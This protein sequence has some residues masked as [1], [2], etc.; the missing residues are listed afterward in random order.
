ME[1]QEILLHAVENGAADIL[2]VAGMPVAYKVNGAIVREGDRLLPP[3]TRRLTEDVY[4]LA[5]NRDINL[6]LENGDDDFPFA[7]PGVSRF[8][9]NALKQ[10]GSLGLVIRVVKFALRAPEELGIPDAVMR[11][12]DRP[13][14][15]VLI[16]GPAGSVKSTTLA[17]LIDRINNTRNSHVI[18]I[19]DPIEFLHQHKMS[20]VTQRELYTDTKSYNA[21]LRAA[22]RESPDVILVGEMRDQETMRAAVTAAE[23]GHLVLSSL[24]TIGAANTIDRIIDSFPPEQ[25]AQIRIQL[26]AAVEGIVSQQLLHSTDGSLVPAFEIMTANP[27]VCNL[28]REAKTHQLDNVIAQSAAEGM[29]LMDQE[30]LRLL[31]T[32]RITKDEALRRCTNSAWM[33]KRLSLQ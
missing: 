15:L 20:V 32:N 9:V 6:L 28:I 25:Q 23:T 22:L 24:H 33:L 17:C 11:L 31:Q 10:R 16:T 7:L 5:D 30:I 4:R 12:A 13:R 21:A 14:G 27:A 1:I 18:T 26:A 3:D 19:E 2:I 8:R 29:V